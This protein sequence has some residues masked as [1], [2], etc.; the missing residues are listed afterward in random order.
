MSEEYYLK[1][2]EKIGQFYPV[3]VDAK[4]EERL[5]VPLKEWQKKRRVEISAIA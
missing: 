4:I 1:K 5:G 3:V 2:S